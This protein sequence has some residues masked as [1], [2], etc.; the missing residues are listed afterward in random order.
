M[1]IRSSGSIVTLAI[2]V[3][4]LSAA[5]SLS[6]PQTSAQ[7]PEP[8]STASKES[9]LKTSPLKTAWGEPDLQGIWTDEYDTPF[10]RPARYGTKEF[11]SEAEREQLDR[12]RAALLGRD[13]RVERGTEQDVAGAYNDVFLSV[14]RTGARTSLIADP[15]NG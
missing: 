1:R 14:K 15:P 8:S 12:Q 2:A 5:I 10:Q 11:F 4:A 6:F 9:P 7:A 13:K 3:A